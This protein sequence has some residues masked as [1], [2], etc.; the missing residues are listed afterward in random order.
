[1]AD[2]CENKRRLRALIAQNGSTVAL[3]VCS[4]EF[5]VLAQLWGRASERIISRLDNTVENKSV[6]CWGECHSTG[7]HHSAGAR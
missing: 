4:K 2:R 6:V 7:L 1:V 5:F 3:V